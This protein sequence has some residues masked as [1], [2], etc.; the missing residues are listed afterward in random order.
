M[1]VPGPML[2]KGEHG[3]LTAGFAVCIAIG[4][5]LIVPLVVLCEWFEACTSSMLDVEP[6]KRTSGETDAMV[7]VDKACSVR[8][9]MREHRDDVRAK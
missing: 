4:A 2:S 6:S 9:L 5:L 1:S 7:R 8:E 3:V